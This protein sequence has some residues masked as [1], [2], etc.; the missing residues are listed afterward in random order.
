MYKRQILQGIVKWRTD[1]TKGAVIECVKVDRETTRSVWVGGR[2]Q[3]KNTGDVQYHDSW[4]RARNYLF[5][6]AV[7]KRHRLLGEMGE[8]EKHIFNVQSLRET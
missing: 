4:E 1:I 6:T 2:M 7:D 8:L 3:L 5:N